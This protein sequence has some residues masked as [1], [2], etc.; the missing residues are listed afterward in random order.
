MNDSEFSIKEPKRSLGRIISLILSLAIVIVLTMA[1]YFYTKVNQAST[2]ENVPVNFSVPKGANTRAV[3]K[4]LSDRNIIN[5]YWGFVLYSK[6]TGT[7]SNI[8]AGNYALNSNMS[9]KKIIDVLTA[10][11]VIPTSRK[12]T[13][14]EGQT[15]KQLARDLESKGIFSSTDLETGLRSGNFKFKYNDVAKNLNYE[16]F[17]FPDTY[18]ISPDA[19]PQQLVQKM[20]VNFESKFNSVAASEIRNKNLNVKNIVTLASIIEKEVGRN[21]DKITVADVA[22]M[23]VERGLV[24]SVFTNRL[25]A[26][27]A[28][29]SDATVNYVTGK[30][31]RSVTIDDTKI[32]S[33]YNT[34]QVVGL[35]PGPISNPGLDSL[36][37]ALHP[38]ASDYLFFLS[39][40]DGTAYFA[41]TL[42]EHNS[43]REKYL[44]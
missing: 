33:P 28:L 24:S 31:D 29:E 13:I 8:Q 20:L 9:I 26:G 19:T 23:K 39:A 32:K 37:A 1:A 5:S 25:A 2:N 6:F 27:M 22:R 18:E 21:K 40:P 41:K 15:N 34:Y 43:N 10:G 11:K 17:L 35:P 3:A 16:G 36:K 30:S 12:V 7:G 44:R 38:T 4:R 14:V 42:A